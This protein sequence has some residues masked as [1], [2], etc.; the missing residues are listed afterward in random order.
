MSSDEKTIA[1]N[2]YCAVVDN[3]GEKGRD[4]QCPS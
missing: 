2:L 3:G 4:G 1:V